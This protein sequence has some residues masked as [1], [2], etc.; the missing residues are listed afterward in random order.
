[1]VSFSAVA[2]GQSSSTA[3]D[4][5]DRTVARRAVEAVNWR[6]PAVNYDRMIQAMVG[7]AKGDF[8]QI[9]YWST[10]LDS[11]NQTLTR[12]MAYQALVQDNAPLASTLRG[13]WPTPM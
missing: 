3:S 2:P 12:Q 7:D 10:L 11:K 8:N 6:I 13:M 1:M 5:V 4:L 9:V